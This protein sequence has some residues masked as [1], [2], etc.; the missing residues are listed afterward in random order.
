MLVV[1]PL[2]EGGIAEIGMK[3][4]SYNQGYHRLLDDL[5]RDSDVDF[6]RVKKSNLIVKQMKWKIVEN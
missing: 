5:P 2:G 3:T 1:L 4:G 6:P